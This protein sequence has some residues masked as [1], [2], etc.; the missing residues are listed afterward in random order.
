MCHKCVE[1]KI[2]KSRKKFLRAGNA[3]GLVIPAFVSSLLLGVSFYESTN[4]WLYSLTV[5]FLVLTVFFRVYSRF[6]S[7]IVIDPEK[8]TVEYPYALR[9][10]DRTHIRLVD[11]QDYRFLNIIKVTIYLKSKE[12]VVF[13]LFLHFIEDPPLR[14]VIEKLKNAFE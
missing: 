12:K 4:S 10:I 13:Y 1:I 5:S 2:S 3:N 8:T 7:F 6:S 11:F 14:K 9:V